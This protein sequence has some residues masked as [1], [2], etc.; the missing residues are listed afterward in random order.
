MVVISGINELL[1]MCIGGLAGRKRPLKSAAH[2]EWRSYSAATTTATTRNAAQ[3]DCAA[4][5][6]HKLEAG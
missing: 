5:G 6:E 3:I 4:L 2:R 1:L